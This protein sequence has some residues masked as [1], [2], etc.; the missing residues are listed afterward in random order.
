MHTERLQL[1]VTLLE[2]VRDT[3]KPDTLFNLGSWAG[4]IAVNPAK[5]SLTSQWL[6]LSSGRRQILTE[7][8]CGTRACAV[9]H[10]CLDPRFNALGLRL[11]D[12][13][14]GNFPVFDGST[15]WEAVEKFF[16]LSASQATRLFYKEEY[17]QGC[18]TPVQ[19]VIDRLKELLA[20]TQDEAVPE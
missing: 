20:P 11:D 10:A 9:G 5:H 15:S 16:G 19:G 3:P 18:R 7:G 4:E 17:P 8:F 12:G 2:E 13:N 14:E 1:L 6:A